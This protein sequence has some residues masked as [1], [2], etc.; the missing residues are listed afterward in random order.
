MAVTKQ[1]SSPSID[2]L[3]AYSKRLFVAWCDKNNVSNLEQYGFDS[4]KFDIDGLPEPYLGNPYNSSAV[5]I[6]INP[7]K[8]VCN[9][10]RHSIAIKTPELYAKHLEKFPYMLC[11]DD[12]Q[13][14][15]CG[16]KWWMIRNQWIK[17]FVDADKNPFGIELCPWHSATWQGWHKLKDKSYVT[18][19][20]VAPIR[21][22]IERSDLGFGLSVGKVVYNVLCDN[23]FS[24][25][26]RWNNDNHHNITRWPKGKKRNYVLLSNEK[27]FILCTW[28]QVRNQ[29]PSNDFLDVEKQI[30]AEILKKVHQE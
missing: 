19:Y 4:E 2:N 8:K 10:C 21:D 25:I 18:E 29:I 7:G 9:N 12:S 23:G 17:R 11:E 24:E 1:Q 22:A 14:N 3:V 28:A 16:T 27:T 26:L 13:E 30:C 5:I 20:L 15:I 6:N